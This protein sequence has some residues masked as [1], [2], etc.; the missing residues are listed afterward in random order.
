M[1]S[2]MSIFLPRRQNDWRATPLPTAGDAARQMYAGRNQVRDGESS[3]RQWHPSF[4]ARFGV[5]PPDGVVDTT[6][7]ARREA[8]S[9][10]VT[11]E[12]KPS[13]KVQRA[14]AERLGK[15]VVATVTATAAALAVA[16]P[17]AAHALDVVAR[18]HD[19]M[20][21]ENRC[22]V[23]KSQE[24]ASHD[25]R[26][27]MKAL[28]DKVLLAGSTYREYVKNGGSIVIDGVTY[29]QFDALWACHGPLGGRNIGKPD[30]K[31]IATCFN[32]VLDPVLTD[33]DPA[34]PLAWMDK[35][36]IACP[37][38]DS[39]R[40]ARFRQL[41]DACSLLTGGK[42][43]MYYGAVGRRMF[44]EMMGLRDEPEPGQCL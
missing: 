1:T 29:T 40:A 3:A 37:L 36:F 16:H 39:E 2:D 9:G 26:A 17:E 6:Y 27:P 32:W 34:P 11:K 14:R 33:T 28:R 41:V 10:G 24:S 31:R 5:A 15:A 19:A 43:N 12:R 8:T 30:A 22:I 7:C 38:S 44:R 20:I 23:R 35:Q 4:M 18:V 25:L 21:E 42:F 13:R